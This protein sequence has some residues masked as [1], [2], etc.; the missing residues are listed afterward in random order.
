[1]LKFKYSLHQEFTN[2]KIKKL[3]LKKKIT[4]FKVFS[5]FLI[6]FKR[7]VYI[8]G[9]LS[10]FLIIFLISYY[11]SSGAHG[12]YTPLKLATEINDK[13]LIRYAGLNLRNIPEYIKI[14]NYNLFKNFNSK[15]LENI[16]LEFD[17]ET[18]LGI[19]L[20]RELRSQKGGELI[21]EEK[22]FYPAILDFDNKKYKVKVRTK[23]VRPL[24]WIKRDET[25]YKIDIIGSERLWGMEEFS[26][27]KPITKNYTYEYLFHKLLGHVGI[28][29]INY[30]FIN[31]YL[32]NQDLGVFAVEE[33]FSKE[34]VERQGKRNGPIFSL[35]DEVGEHFPN[36][37]YELYSSEYWISEHNALTKNV[38][39]ILNNLKEENFDINNH[40]DIDKW[41]KYFAVIDLTGSYHGSLLK[42][43]KLFYNPTSALFE[44]IGFDLHKN[45]GLFTNFILMDFLKEPGT[46]NKIDCSYLC[47]HTDWY[48]K[49][50]KKNDNELN[51]DF[52]KRYIYYLKL[53]SSD[54]F[55]KNFIENYADE[56]EIY[57]KAIYRDNS[58]TDR[59]RR[60]GIGYFIFNDDYIYDRAKLI[61]SR[62]EYIDTIGIDI[63]FKND[64]LTFSQKGKHFPFPVQA[65][66]VNCDSKISNYS[67]LLVETMTVKLNNQCKQLL[68]TTFSNKKKIFELKENI[69]LS[70]NKNYN[71]KENFINLSHFSEV[72]KIENNKYKIS[73]N[74]QIQKNTILKKEDSFTFEKNTNVDI[75]NGSTLY[76]EGKIFFNNDENTLTKIYSSDGTGSLVFFNNDFDLKNII[77]D[78]L[79]RP[80]LINKIL[81]GGVNIIDSNVSLDNIYVLNS[82][83]EDGLNIINSV[84]LINKIYFENIFADAFDV[85]FGNLK[86]K[87]I[88]CKNI[89]NDC[90]D[91]SGAEVYGENLSSINAKDKGVSVGENSKIEILNLDTSNNNIGLAVKDGSNAYFKNIIFT[92]NNFDIALF[93]KKNEFLKP[94][95]SI[96]RLNK[97]NTDKILQSKDTD[98]IINNKS[99]SGVLKDA[100]INSIIY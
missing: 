11:Y 18:I 34:L 58:K 97:I 25:S 72:N 46:S 98:L 84:S 62:I 86:F 88:F 38:F 26:I 24:H 82:N 90:L 51:D 12:R 100:Y 89:N 36:V 31:L 44:P 14:F 20:Q 59:F 3:I 94:S 42:S 68:I 16:Y 10:L 7:L 21:D 67:F 28:V 70:N 30:F 78:N 5:K 41:A 95:L 2:S 40:F 74:I 52:L 8:T 53:Y 15:D 39:S 29:N 32:N 4:E 1:M 43:V 61:K 65:E 96:D 77:F 71:I 33:S 55:I 48:L 76:I 22:I 37:R 9:F 92:E 50:L 75:L 85:D 73:T 93:N 87:N 6:F 45:D 27:Q 83:D 64:V 56:L 81:Y 79:A 57:N 13:I 66:L 54:E 63:S 99:Y 17:Q 49:F 80:N 91:I 23:G 69:S 35:K 19:E 60:A 47:Y